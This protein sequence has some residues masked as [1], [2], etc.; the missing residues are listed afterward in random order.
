MPAQG[1]IIESHM[2]KGRGAVAEAMVEQG[3]L[4]AGDFIAAGVYLWQSP[5]LRG[6][7]WQSYKRGWSVHPVVIAG[8]KNL[9]ELRRRV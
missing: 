5:K 1:L 8:I 3:T 9:P 4:H 6:N 2:E 7:G